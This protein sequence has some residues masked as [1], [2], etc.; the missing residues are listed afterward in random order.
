MED[1][2]VTYRGFEI[3]CVWEYTSGKSDFEVFPID[4]ESGW[5]EPYTTLGKIIISI[6]EKLA[7]A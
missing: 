2:L 6:D 4:G 1:N 5:I 3:I 7:E